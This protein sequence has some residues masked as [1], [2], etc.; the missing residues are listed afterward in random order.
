MSATVLAGVTDEPLLAGR[1]QYV[2]DVTLPGIVEAAFVRSTPGPRP[3]HRASA[4]T[5]PASDPGV[6]DVVTAADLAG[7]HALTRTSSR[8]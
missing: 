8:G 7:R 3:D 4:S 1:A 6:L 2:A 5:T